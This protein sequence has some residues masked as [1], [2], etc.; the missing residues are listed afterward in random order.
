HYVREPLPCG[1][2]G[3][4]QVG[5]QRGVKVIPRDGQRILQQPG[6]SCN[7]TSNRCAVPYQRAAMPQRLG[8]DKV[9]RAFCQKCRAAQHL[10]WRKPK[11]KYLLS[12]R[13]YEEISGVSLEQQKNVFGRMS[14]IDDYG[15]QLESP[16]GC[17][18]QDRLQLRLSQS[19][20]EA[21]LQ[22]PHQ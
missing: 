1:V 10:T 19:L 7:K 13:C 11:Q 2:A 20:Q 21:G 15:V 16:Q 3:H 6:I 18:G 9:M 22:L 12:I 17:G 8:A 5:R 14:L 4:R